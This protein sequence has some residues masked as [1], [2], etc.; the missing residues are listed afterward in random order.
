VTSRTYARLVNIEEFLKQ[1]VSFT[2]IGTEAVAVV[3]VAIGVVL[4]V[5]RIAVIRAPQS[6]IRL[7]LGRWLALALEFELAADVMRTALNY[8]LE[9]DIDKADASSVPPVAKSQSKI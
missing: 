1:L 3:I 9:R 6:A 4:T 7:Y 2:A 5:A 8:F